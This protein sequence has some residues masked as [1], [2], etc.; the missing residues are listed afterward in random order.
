MFLLGDRSGN[1]CRLARARKMIWLPIGTSQTDMGGKRTKGG[2]M[3][4]LE[5]KEEVIGSGEVGAVEIKGRHGAR[6]GSS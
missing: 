2:S 4:Q 6:T 3:G 1:S 5:Q